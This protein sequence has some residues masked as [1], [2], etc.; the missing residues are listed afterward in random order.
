MGSQ[1]IH[2]ESYGR[3]AGK[4]KQA[5][6]TIDS[7]VGEAERDDGQCYHVEN[8]IKPVILY[9]TSFRDAGEEAKKWAE[10]AKDARGHKL[11]KD[12]LCIVAGVI[13]APD[14][15]EDWEKY[16]KR[17][18]S[19]LQEKYGKNLKSVIEHTDENHK[20]IHFAVVPEKGCSFETIHQGYKAQ[21]EADPNRGNRKR[22][23]EEKIAGRRKGVIA[24]QSAMRGYQ[25]DFYE[26]VSRIHGLTRIGPARRR[27]TRSAWRQE[28]IQAHSIA[29]SLVDIEE[30]ALVADKLKNINL[31]F[32]QKLE[33]REK[34]VKEAEKLNPT[35]EF[36]RENFQGLTHEQ[37]RQ[38]WV[39]LKQQAEAIR[40][41][42][43]TNT[44]TNTNN[45]TDG[46]KHSGGSRK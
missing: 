45:L 23:A 3:E 4:G 36:L 13:S 29:N 34:N 14:D 16:K 10:D 18:L 12:A 32:H 44:K 27:L 21:K 22:S 20:H 40:N 41:Q 35:G 15:L 43:C 8:P 7:I 25:D 31:E 39:A 6:H 19:W 46:I 1:F 26:K 11:R 2:V 33:K 37:Q 24:Y 17:S 30:L 38:C 28:Q 5:G 42:S 9:G